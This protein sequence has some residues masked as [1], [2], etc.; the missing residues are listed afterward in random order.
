MIDKVVPHR[1]YQ[2]LLAVVL[3]YIITIAF[4]S[5]FSYMRQHLML[6]ATSKIDARLASRTFAHVLRLPMA[7]FEN[8]P[9]GVL[10]RNVTQT[11]AVRGFL[12]GRVFFTILDCLTLPIL[13][14]GLAIY[15]AKL[16]AV[17]LVFSLLIAAVIGGMIPTFR[18]QLELLYAAE[19]NRQADLVETVHGMRAVKS[20]ALE[21]LR[22][23][24]WDTKVAASAR[25][26]FS[27]GQ[28]GAYGMIAVSSLQQL[29]QISI[30]GVGAMFVF[31]NDL[32]IGTLVAFNMLSGRVTG[33]LIAL[34]SLIN[35]YEQT[36]LSVRMLGTVMN[37]PPERDP[38]HQG[39]R[40]VITGEL[41]FDNVIFKYDGS[42]RP[43]L[44]RVTFKVK[45]GQVIGLV[46]RSGSGKT[47]VT[48]LIQGIH[49]AQEGLI[50]LNGNDIRHI[51]LQH[52]RRSIGVV[53]QDNILFRGTIR[54]NI[55][56]SKPSATLPEVMEA[57][58]L[59][60]ADE[61]IDRLPMSYDTPVGEG[62]S[63]F[64][65]GQRQRIAIA[66]AL[67]SRP[68]LL[69][70]DEATSALDPES[71]AIVQNNLAAI[72]EGRTMLIVSHR[73]SSLVNADAILVLDQG[74]PVDFAP[75]SVL[76]E[77]CEI[78]RHLWQQQTQ[79]IL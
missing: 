34:V 25:R 58:R 29:M 43:A 44:D 55:A 74:K 73:L 48:R 77:R 65:G 38:N 59:A 39:I 31:D 28:F 36:A 10:I 3:A 6:F 17:V 30:L 45:E 27:V 14:V 22:K 40:P 68:R 76:V 67:L 9:T 69:I 7:F 46:G 62:A 5:W 49:T 54:D 33:P 53:L 21:D 79:H 50:K 78:Y 2:T 75:H 72:A 11:E 15:S 4:D 35:E 47:T 42:Y 13:V 51:D 66:R 52:L 20:L 37:H 23:Q 41:E 26:R 56:A 19:G 60:G 63:N 8:T 57:A 70:F 1:S 18:R 32:T 71:E 12:T 64:S 61:F 24:S 16:T